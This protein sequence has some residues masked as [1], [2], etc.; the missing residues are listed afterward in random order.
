MTFELCLWS[1]ALVL[2][3]LPS[4]LQQVILTVHVFYQY[5]VPSPN[6]QPVR[7]QVVW[8]LNPLHVLNELLVF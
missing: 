8:S 2:Q 5:Q 7:L 1:K 6:E 3:L 4:N